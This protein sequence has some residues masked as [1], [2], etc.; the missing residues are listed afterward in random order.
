M[1]VLI[2]IL[3]FIIV[4]AFISTL[5]FAIVESYIEQDEEYNEFTEESDKDGE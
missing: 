1:I 5:A 2:Y 3:L 4:A